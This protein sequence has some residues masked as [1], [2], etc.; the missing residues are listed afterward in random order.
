MTK[1]Q[2]L[3]SSELNKTHD[4]SNFLEQFHG[5]ECYGLLGQI[6]FLSEEKV[7]LMLDH[8]KISDRRN[9]MLEALEKITYA[10]IAG[11]EG[12]YA[13][14]I[15]LYEQVLD[16]VKVLNQG[17][18]QES[19]LTFFYYEY[20]GFLKRIG[21]KS[22]AL[23]YLERAQSTAKSNRMK[24]MI[25]YQFMVKQSGSLKKS[26]LRK[27]LQSIAYFNKYGMTVMETQAHFDLA[28]YYMDQDEISEASTHLDQAHELAATSG[29]QYLRW[30]I[31]LLRGDLL[32]NQNRESE[33]IGYFE[34]LLRST[35]NNYFK[36]R[37]L[38]ELAGLYE[39][40]GQIEKALETAM[41]SM[42]LSQRFS[43]VGE[44][45]KASLKIGDLYHRQKTDITKAFFYF[46]QGYGSVMEL[47]KRGVPIG[48]EQTK[49]IDMYISF[50]E[51]HFPGDITESA[52]EDLFAFSKE[53]NWVRIKDLFHY[54]LFLYHYMNTGIGNKT[55]KALKFPASSFYSATERLR[56]RGVT[57][58]NFRRN[59]VEIPAENYVEGLQQYSRMHREKSWFEINEQ[60]EKDMLAYHY[61]IN[62]Y[63][64][65]LLAKNL[66]LAYSGIVNRT[67]YLTSSNS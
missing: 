35:E 34:E 25:I 46:Q 16:K 29:Y 19:A 20:S 4:T 18:Q 17:S 14:A 45:A 24:Q 52:N 60:F 38:N 26:A 13:F 3:I 67:K 7:Q 37:I 6:G 27:W 28:K 44:L 56:S 43:I 62:S 42:E 2:H 61:K 22:A 55:L 66:E 33:A 59:D 49:V 65:K 47:A 48:T 31:E 5:A 36:T 50:L 12:N 1:R 53:L 57:F 21:D 23:M 64:K 15:E 39:H 10:K 30:S 54:N 51:E 11:L 58:P 9:K 63:N 41:A 40:D 8:G 32:V